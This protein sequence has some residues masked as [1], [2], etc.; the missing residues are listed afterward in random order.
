M[1]APLRQAPALEILAKLEESEWWESARIERGQQRRLE[2]LVRHAADTVPF[3]R[4]RAQTFDTLPIIT[5]RDLQD[6]P[7]ALLS[8]KIPARVGRRYTKRSSGSTGEP[9]KV[10]RT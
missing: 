7:D 2:S 4:G 3:Y 5:R 10:V 6:Q 9:V 8:T 1:N